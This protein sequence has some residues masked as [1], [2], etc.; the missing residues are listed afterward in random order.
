MTNKKVNNNI[1]IENAR[2]IFRNFSGTE[3][4]YNPA[5]KRNF[6]VLIDDD[7]ASVLIEDGWN[8]KYLKPVDENDDPQAYM[9]VS[10]SY[11]TIP[12][13]IVMVSSK[14]KT[15]LDETNVGQLDYADIARVDMIIRPYNWE[16]R[17]ATGVKGYVK[18]LWVTIEED[19][20]EKKYM[21]VP[22]LSSGQNAVSEDDE[23]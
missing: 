14:G 12:P 15:V 16:V 22:E 1:T 8:V 7:L 4:Q 21:T 2:I 9:Q 23:D 6:C 13:K 3:S 20:L 11:N 10:V 5:G 19:E 18:S 17:G